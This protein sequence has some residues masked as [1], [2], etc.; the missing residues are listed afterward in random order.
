MPHDM[1]AACC[2]PRD[3]RYSA[4]DAEA[5]G[6]K[7]NSLAMT[8]QPREHAAV[9]FVDT[10]GDRVEYRV[11]STSNKLDVFVN[12]VRMAEGLTKLT[13]NGR[14]IADEKWTHGKCQWTGHTTAPDEDTARRV[15][16][17]FNTCNSVTFV[18]TQGDQVE[19]RVDSTSN[20]LDVFE[21][22]VLIG[23]D[24]TK[25]TRNGRTIIDHNNRGMDK[26]TAWMT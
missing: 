11:N 12:D 9:T 19:F 14:T 4:D 1:G 17:L 20:K 24:L 26:T 21:N 25:L 22:D 18:D 10:D 6:R 7:M 13:R 2:H 5:D 3:V 15:I 8:S 16:E 23:K